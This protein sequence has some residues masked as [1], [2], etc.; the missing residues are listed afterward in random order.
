MNRPGG[1]RR[2]GAD[3]GIEWGKALVLIVVLVVIG[4]VILNKTGSSSTPARTAGTGHHGTTGSTT[5]TTL[6][7][8]STT[9]TP[10]LAPAQVKVQVLNGVL[11]GNLASQWSTKLKS[12]FGYVTELPDNA[13]AKVPTSIIY[14]ITPGY[15]AEAI[16][17][18]TAVGL[19]AS[20]VY[21]TIPPPASA[22]IPTAERSTA[23]LVLMIGPDLASSA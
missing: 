9:T 4:V 1:G 3:G 21:P 15:Q 10:A 5:T 7:A 11:T 23:N 20:A 22:P 19:T 16:Q 2:A 12:R 13:T 8:P 18:A 17:L 6:P 14:V